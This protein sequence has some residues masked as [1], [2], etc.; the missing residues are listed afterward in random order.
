MVMPLIRTSRLANIQLSVLCFRVV[1]STRRVKT[2]TC[3]VMLHVCARGMM[4]LC[5]VSRIDM[6][7]VCARFFCVSVEKY[8]TRYNVGWILT[9]RDNSAVLIVN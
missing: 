4:W 7:H 3:R 8:A 2:L 6:C 9:F 5:M 1:A